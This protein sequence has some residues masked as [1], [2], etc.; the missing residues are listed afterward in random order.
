MIIQSI[1]FY[2]NEDK[3]I[4]IRMRTKV[5]AIDYKYFIE[6]NIPPYKVNK[7]WLDEIFKRIPELPLERYNKYI[8]DYGLDSYDAKIIIKN[9]DISDYYEE[10]LKLKMNPK[11]TS[12]W[13]TTIIIGILNKE[14][15]NIKDFFIKPIYLKEIIDALEENKI[16][17]KQAKEIFN[18]AIVELKEPKE[19]LKESSQ[20]SNKDEL[21][22]I[23][24]ELI[25]N[26]PKEKEAYLNGKTNIFD[27]FVGQV[28]KE[29]KG[30]ANPNITKEILKEK[31]Q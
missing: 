10:C 16:S 13:L 6:P 4:T 27:F 25:N 30:K 24:I 29:T 5:D 23:I 1:S 11:L 21:S 7:E 31:L 14:E 2:T 18:K 28:M 8:N 26:H 17:S 15:I 9:K 19:Y 20:I 22:N 12:N 3:G